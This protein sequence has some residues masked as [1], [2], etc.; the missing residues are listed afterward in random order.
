VL[1]FFLPKGGACLLLPVLGVASISASGL[2][3]MFERLP[4][5]AWVVT[6]GSALVCAAGFAAAVRVHPAFA[7]PA[8]IAAM[9]A[10]RSLRGRFIARQNWRRPRS[11]G[12]MCPLCRRQHA[13]GERFEECQ[14]QDCRRRAGTASCV[15]DACFVQELT[16]S[17]T[18]RAYRHAATLG[19][20]NPRGPINAPPA[21]AVAVAPIVS[22]GAASPATEHAMLAAIAEHPDDDGPRLVLADAWAEQGESQGEFA[23]LSI[24]AMQQTLAPLGERKLREKRLLDRDRSKWVPPGV[25]ARTATFHRGFLTSCKLVSATDPSHRGWITVERLRCENVA[26][27]P[28]LLRSGLP[29]LREISGVDAGVLT[30]LALG[31]QRPR[32]VSIDLIVTTG[33]VELIPLLHALPQLTTLGL[34][35]L[36]SAPAQFQTVLRLLG[37]RYP[38]LRLALSSVDI[39]EALEATSAGVAPSTIELRVARHASPTWLILNRG[40]L[41]ARKSA[42]SSLAATDWRYVSERVGNARALAMPV[43]ESSEGE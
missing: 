18:S 4:F 9:V 42:S 40:A 31:A 23:M 19:S 16:D 43:T 37:G 41:S 15:C 28:Q 32:L 6:I 20:L 11:P 34:C 1:A 30:E 3:S 7:A 33:L 38:K 10:W 24:T 14:Y 21:R 36:E 2:D 8:L 26:P 17:S 27:P 25:D 13:L 39:D 5:T 29:L 35:E 12:P 22:T